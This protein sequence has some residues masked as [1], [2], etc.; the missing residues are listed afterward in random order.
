M[1]KSPLLMGNRQSQVDV[2]GKPAPSKHQLRTPVVQKSLQRTGQSMPTIKVN[3][4]EDSRLQKVRKLKQ[5]M[6]AFQDKVQLEKD[7]AA[8]VA[9]N[10]SQGDAEYQDFYGARKPDAAGSFGAGGDETNIISGAGQ[11]KAVNSLQ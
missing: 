8:V 2:L 7:A 5:Q 9:R 4:Y 11:I 1:E 3:Y 10:L 6:Q